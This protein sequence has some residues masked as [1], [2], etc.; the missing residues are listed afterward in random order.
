MQPWQAGP[1]GAKFQEFREGGLCFPK[2]ALI[3]KSLCLAKIAHILGLLFLDRGRGLGF[4]RS[5][6]VTPKRK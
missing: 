3:H 5:G 6:G 1:T 2:G 4:P